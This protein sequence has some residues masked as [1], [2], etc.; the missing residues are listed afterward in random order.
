MMRRRSGR[1]RDVGRRDVG[2]SYVET[3]TAVVVVSIIAVPLLSA[4]ASL[5]R[6]SAS[7]G[8]RAEADNVLRVI[9][10]NVNRVVTTDRCWTAVDYRAELDDVLTDLGWQQP[11]TV[12]VQHRLP[13]DAPTMVGPWMG[14]ACPADLAADQDYLQL[15]TISVTSPRGTTRTLRMVKGVA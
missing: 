3:V 12:S 8:D 11:S 4:V 1:R 15:V 6:T 5:I 7:L 2:S 10:D 14:E 9:A 13:T